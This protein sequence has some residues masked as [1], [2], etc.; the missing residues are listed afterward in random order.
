MCLNPQNAII[1]NDGSKADF[2]YLNSLKE[3]LT[4]LP[5]GKCIQCIS[6]RSIEWATRCRHEMSTHLDSSFI[7]LTY[8]DK[9]IQ[10][11]EIVYEDF[12]KFMFK[13]RKEYP[14]QV[15]YIVSCEYG[16][17]YKRPHFHTIL[18]GL[19]P[20]NQKH[21]R[22]TPK[23]SR[24]YTSEIIS[25]LWKHG[26][27]SIGEAS[28]KTA[29]YIASYALSNSKHEIVRPDGELIDAQDTMK[30]SKRP[31]IGLNFFL[32]NYESIIADSI[33]TGKPIP[34][35]YLKKL[36]EL[37][38]TLHSEYKIF[39]ESNIKIRSISNDYAKILEYESKNKILTP[40]D[41]Q[42]K[43]FTNLKQ[44]VKNQLSINHALTKEKK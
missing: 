44:I 4:P 16:T 1:K 11:D 23:G 19:N 20:P 6:K 42:L 14:K 29:Y 13:I 25:D 9:N 21:I 3:N 18:F 24:L 33:H 35:Y 31:A 40:H 43:D 41:R 27:H 15:R 2:T 17:N 39:K 30:S 5:C 34:R 36:E 32:K 10:S 8:D 37:H 26:F 28:E 22:T 7:T 38:P 12:Q